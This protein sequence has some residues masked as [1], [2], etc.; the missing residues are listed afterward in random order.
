MKESLV[1][2]G[3]HYCDLVRFGVGDWNIGI[4]E[5]WNDRLSLEEGHT[6][7]RGGLKGQ[8]D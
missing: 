2:I 5:R 6:A 4:M 8:R 7:E 1:L 3:A